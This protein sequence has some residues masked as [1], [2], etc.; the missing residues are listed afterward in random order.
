MADKSITKVE[1]YLAQGL[2]VNIQNQFGNTGLTLAC[3]HGQT[4]IVRCL[5]AKGANILLCGSLSAHNQTALHATAHS[6]NE[7]IASL[8]I[9]NG[10]SVNAQ[11]GCGDTPLHLAAR[12]GHLNLV[13]SY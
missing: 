11:D 2:D 13:E 3:F 4:Y 5:L 6:G 7:D 10:L 12:Y 1:N 9:E 8:L